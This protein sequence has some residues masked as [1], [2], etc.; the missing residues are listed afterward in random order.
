MPAYRFAPD[1]E[2]DLTEIWMYSCA[3]WGEDQADRY[4]E[5]LHACCERIVAGSAA[6]RTVAGLDGVQTHHCRHH[7]LFFTQ[8]RGETVILAVLH[9]RMDLI[10]RLRDRL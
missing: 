4:I 2:D 3:S 5:A 8:Q 7:Y 1:A 9:E 6:V 10:K